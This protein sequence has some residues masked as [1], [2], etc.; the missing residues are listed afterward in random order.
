MPPSGSM[1]S[2]ISK[3]FPLLQRNELEKILE[4]RKPENYAFGLNLDHTSMSL[5]R[6]YINTDP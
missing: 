4:F 5:L 2:S 3:Y 1:K 6:D